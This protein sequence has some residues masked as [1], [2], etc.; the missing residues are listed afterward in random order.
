MRILFVLP[1]VPFPPINGGRNKVFNIL[2]YLSLRHRC[3]LIYFGSNDIDRLEELRRIL[4][5]LGDINSVS[6]PLRIERILTTLINIITLRPISF[7]GYSSCKMKKEILNFNK[8]NKYDVIHFDIINMAQYYYLCPNIPSLHSPN[9]ATSLVYSRLSKVAPSSINRLR[10]RVM[11]WLIAYYERNH[12]DKFDVIHVVSEMDAAYLLRQV[13]KANV[14]VVP[15]SSGYSKDI[16]LFP[17]MSQSCEH[18]TIAICGNMGNPGISAG[19]IEFLEYVYPMVRNSFSDLRFRV[20]G[21]FFSEQ[22]KLK[23]KQFAN[24]ECLDWV[25]DFPEF[26][27]QADL[28]LLPDKVGAPG[29]KTR[30]LQAMALGK[31]VMGGVAAFEGVPIISGYH[32]LVYQNPQECSDLM[33]NML[34]DV[35]FREKIGNAAKIFAA[36]NYSIESLGPK[37]EAIYEGISKSKKLK[38]HM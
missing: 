11:S 20:L 1:E 13:P 12:Y 35:L 31:P 26:L 10:F 5:E 6:R 16:V 28:V 32:A 18:L 38:Y 7:A 14:I 25:E 37:Y 30:T 9:D 17:S 24:I 22:L 15:V 27:R 3:D 29:P 19:F 4:P 33:I 2:K 36:D 8:K 21:G 23:L 34:R